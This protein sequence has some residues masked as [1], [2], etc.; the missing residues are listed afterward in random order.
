MSS[1]QQK[2]YK[3]FK[4]AQKCDLYNQKKTKTKT[5]TSNYFEGIQML[6]LADI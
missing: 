1:F 6:D 4:E 5:D 2:I 3:I